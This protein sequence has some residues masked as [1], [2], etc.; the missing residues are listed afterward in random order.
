MPGRSRWRSDGSDG[1]TSGAAPHPI[2]TGWPGGHQYVWNRPPLRLVENMNR[3][4][5]IS[6]SQWVM[7]LEND[8]CLL[9]GAGDAMREAIRRAGLGEAVLLFGFQIVDGD[10][11]RL[12]EQRFRRGR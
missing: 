9:P 2:V 10:G 4:V 1:D 7:Q 11:V 3:A 5:E 12:R 8:D 6:T